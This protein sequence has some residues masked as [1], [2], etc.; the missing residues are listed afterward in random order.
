MLCFSADL[1]LMSKLS[2]FFQILKLKD[3]LNI[4]LITL[5]CMHSEVTAFAEPSMNPYAERRQRSGG[6]P[7]LYIYQ[8]ELDSSVSD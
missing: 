2:Y 5:I 8:T 4:V 7:S 3:V 1:S 6:L